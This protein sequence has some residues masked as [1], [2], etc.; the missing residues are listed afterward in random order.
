MDGKMRSI[1]GKSGVNG[2]K[3][4]GKDEALGFPPGFKY[5]RLCSP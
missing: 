4:G 5:G 3:G 2:R 1:G